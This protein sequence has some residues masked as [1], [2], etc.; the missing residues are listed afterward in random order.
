MVR[1]P[2]T[3]ESEIRAGMN[4]RAIGARSVPSRKTGARP[5]SAA[6]RPKSSMSGVKAMANIQM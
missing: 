2:R 4:S 6:C 5:S 3:K 1:A